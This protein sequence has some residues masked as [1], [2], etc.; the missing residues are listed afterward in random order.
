M[1]NDNKARH[2]AVLHRVG[3]HDQV[4]SSTAQRLARAAIRLRTIDLIRDFL[5]DSVYGK[6]VEEGIIQRELIE[7]E[8]QYADEEVDRISA[9][10]RGPSD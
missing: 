6:S 7:L 10:A 8:L 2:S 1:D 5:E 9:A 4:L 3:A